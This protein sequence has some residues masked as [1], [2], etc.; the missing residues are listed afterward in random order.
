[1]DEQALPH[2]PPEYVKAS[3]HG[4]SSKASGG[5]QFLVVHLPQR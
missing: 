3:Q 1:M 5:I 2:L 4:W